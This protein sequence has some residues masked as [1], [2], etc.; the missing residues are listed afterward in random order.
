M[1]RREEKKHSNYAQLREIRLV[2]FVSVFWDSKNKMREKTS[3]VLPR[4]DW[5][6]EFVD[7]LP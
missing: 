2:E 6:A 7:G 1:K 4:V 3:L 5:L